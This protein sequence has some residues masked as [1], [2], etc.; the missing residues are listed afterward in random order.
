[1]QWGKQVS[2][3]HVT[4]WNMDRHHVKR[5]YA[6][7][8]HFQQAV[9]WHFYSFVFS[10]PS[11]GARVLSPTDGLPLWMLLLGKKGWPESWNAESNFLWVC[12]LDFV[13]TI[14]QAAIALLTVSRA[15]TQEDLM[16]DC[17]SYCQWWVFRMKPH[18]ELLLPSSNLLLDK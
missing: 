13:E 3:K 10:G 16:T 7:S 4:L 15:F 9:A 5:Q 1:M 11:T 12:L 8:E 6:H 18:W 17:E 14:Y 2:R